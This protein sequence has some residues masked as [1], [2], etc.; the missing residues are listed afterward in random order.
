MHLGEESGKWLLWTHGGKAHGVYSLAGVVRGI[1]G[2]VA[3]AVAAKEAGSIL[4]G[5]RGPVP[6]LA[7]PWIWSGLDPSAV[8]HV[9]WVCP[10]RR[11][12]IRENSF[13]KYSGLWQNHHYWT[14]IESYHHLWSSETENQNQNIICICINCSL[15]TWNI[16]YEPY[17]LY[18]L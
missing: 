10:P 9:V 1:F 18:S 8:K 11:L 6:W 2:A 15:R 13:I 17:G 5:H 14:N 12:E 16:M 4:W 3:W 7:S